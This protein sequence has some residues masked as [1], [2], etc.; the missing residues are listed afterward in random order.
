M[1]PPPPGYTI[2]RDHL[3]HVCGHRF[4]FYLT[5]EG[6]PRPLSCPQCDAPKRRHLGPSYSHVLSIYGGCGGVPTAVRGRAHLP[7]YKLFIWVTNEADVAAW[8]AAILAFDAIE[9]VDHRMQR[10]EDKYASDEARRRGWTK[11]EEDVAELAALV[12]VRQQAESGLLRWR[13]EDLGRRVVEMLRAERR[14]HLHIRD[15]RQAVA[16]KN[17]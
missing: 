7:E 5:W 8:I 16:E 10:I 11:N 14:H 3:C 13:I 1:Q 6:K 9:M 12:L 17:T 15:T 4:G 2:P